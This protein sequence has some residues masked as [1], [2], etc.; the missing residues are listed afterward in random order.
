[1]HCCKPN[2]FLLR[3]LAQWFWW[4]LQHRVRNVHHLLTVKLDGLSLHSASNTEPVSWN[5]SISLWTA[6]QW[7]TS[8]SGNFTANCSFTKSVHLLP[9]QKTHSTRK[10]CSSIERTTVS[11]NWIKQTLSTYCSLSA[12]WLSECT[13]FNFFVVQP[14]TYWRD[15]QILKKSTSHHQILGPERKNVQRNTFHNDDSQF[16]TDFEPHC[17]CKI[18]LKIWRCHH[19]KL[20]LGICAHRPS[21][22]TNYNNTSST[23]H[24]LLCTY[25]C[26]EVLSQW[27]TNTYL[28]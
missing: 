10:T 6:L 9:S 14:I 21:H 20:S 8:V 15:K 25:I 24:L 5:F 22:H 26:T 1:M 11:K 27:A 23:N 18:M 17:T 2:I 3:Q 19:I 4:T 7:G 28:P 12:Q 13:V 16:W